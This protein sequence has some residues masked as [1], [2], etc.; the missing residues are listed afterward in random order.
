[1]D[2]I[3]RIMVMSNNYWDEE[4]INVMDKYIPDDAVIVD[5]GAYIGSHSVYWAVERHAKKI[6]AFEPLQSAYEIMEILGKEESLNRI[7]KAIAML[8]E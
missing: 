7:R 8:A 2:V 5:I 3:Q 1:M 4:A 6:Y